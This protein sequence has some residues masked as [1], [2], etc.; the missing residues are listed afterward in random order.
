MMTTT[1]AVIIVGCVGTSPRPAD[2]GDL[3]D[4]QDRAQG[5]VSD[6]IGRAAE[7]ELGARGVSPGL[8][9]NQI[10]ALCVR[11]RDD[12]VRGIDPSTT[13]WIVPW[14]PMRAG[15]VASKTFRAILLTLSS[16]GSSGKLTIPV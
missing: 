10:G 5:P 14:N 15:R 4:D 16:D 3:P 13:S 12:L 8:G 6:G 1:E 7:A 2:M 9:E 11:E